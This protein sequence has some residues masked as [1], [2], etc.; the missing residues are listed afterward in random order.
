MEFK[1]YQGF[2]KK[3]IVYGLNKGL[4]SDPFDVPKLMQIVEI[5]AYGSKMKNIVNNTEK[6]YTQELELQPFKSK[7]L[8]PKSWGYNLNRIDFISNFDKFINKPKVCGIFTKII[9][10][11]NF[12][13]RC[14]LKQ[15]IRSYNFYKKSI[16]SGNLYLKINYKNVYN[17]IYKSNLTLSS[18]KY[19]KYA[20][21][22]S[23]FLYNLINSIYYVKNTFIWISKGF[24]KQY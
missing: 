18:Y 19:E 24:Y 6:Y 22:I 11:V 5:E 17:Y 20:L 3:S 10:C 1:T 8:P 7:F 2:E 4:Y 9:Y 14:S 23:L 16:N 13:N 12:I 15:F 21:K